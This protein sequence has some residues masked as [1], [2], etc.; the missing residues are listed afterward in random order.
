MQK[1][2]AIRIATSSAG[3]RIEAPW[4]LTGTAR[5]V[6]GR[7][8]YD[9]QLEFSA[10]DSPKSIAFGGFWEKA[11]ARAPLDGRMSLEGWTVHWLGPMTSSSEQGTT[12]DYAAQPVSAHWADLASLRKYIAD[13]PS[14]R[15]RRRAP[16]D[17]ANPG[18][19][20]SIS[21]ETF[22][23]NKQGVRR[24]LGQGVREYRPGSDVV[25]ENTQPTASTKTLSLN[26]G[27]SISSDVYREK[28]LTGFG[29][30]LVKDDSPG[31]SWEWFDRDRG[32]VFRKL[33]GGGKVR[34][35][36]VKSGESQ[37]LVAVEFLDDITLSCTDDQ[38]G[39]TYEARVRKG[40]VF[41]VAP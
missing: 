1:R 11:A 6:D 41:R 14:R 21:Y 7:I 39:A 29:L 19:P 30:V 12:L 24:R 18:R 36:V 16:A 8:V 9:M 22:E 20:E 2:R 38:T 37:E 26:Y 33:R 17:A 32:D 31:F 28:E 3:G 10:R 25:V 15:A 40:S 4:T 13:E 23:V 27:L 35:T 34:V 5:Q